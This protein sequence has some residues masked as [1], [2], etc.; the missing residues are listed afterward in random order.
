MESPSSAPL[1][2]LL[3]AELAA[4]TVESLHALHGPER[5]WVY[6]LILGGVVAALASLPLIRVD[7]GFRARGVVRPITDRVELKTTLSGRISQ[8][9]AADNEFVRRGQVLLVIDAAEIDEQLRRQR[10]LAREQEATLADLGLL[11]VD[12]PAEDTLQ[13]AALRQEVR[14]HRAQLDTY[15]LA[16][17][18]AGSEL[19]R[20]TALAARGI[21]TRQELDNARY[22]VERLAAES[23]LLREQ[24]RARWAVQLRDEAARLADV[25]SA[26]HQLE[27]AQEQRIVRAPVDGT[28]IG[29]SGWAGGGR[30]VAGQVLGT[31]SPADGLCVES[32]VSSRD[33]GLVRIGQTV[34]L[35]VD[36]F[37]YTQ[38]GT[39]EARVESVSADFVAGAAAA[40]AQFKVLLR[41]AATHLV[42]PGGLR[43]ELRKGLTLTARYVVGQRSLLQILYDEASVWLGPQ[44]AV[45]AP[46]PARP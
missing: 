14:Q 25:R 11:A 12:L 36:A 3:P 18:K 43:G 16:E 40:P 15:R 27:E 35:Q 30:V 32:Q 37:P 10:E 34:R 39:L 9:L 41:P 5:R 13:T 46:P 38:W 45:P 44:G 42:L 1:A 22:E 21:T 8:V 28:L 7:V 6:W 23:R 4:N 19:A 26:I 31:V 17:A 20:Y 33:I 24:A 2:A 29:F